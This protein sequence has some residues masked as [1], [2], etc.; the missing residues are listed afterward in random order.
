VGR[1]EEARSRDDHARKGLIKIHGDRHPFTLSANINYA[2]DLAACGGLGQA[3]QLGQETLANCRLY[4]GEDH[5]DTLM[6]AANLSCDEVTAGDVTNGDRRLAEVLR[7]YEQKLTLEHPDARAA[8]QRSRLTA[9]IE[10][11]DL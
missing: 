10:P 7:M 3:I 1:P 2:S 5:P 11:Y 9:E 4:L 8:A 6:A